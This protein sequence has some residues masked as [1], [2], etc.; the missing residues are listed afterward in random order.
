MSGHSF[1]S[2]PMRVLGVLFALADS[3]INARP[4]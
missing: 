3:A 4:R 2:T 1:R